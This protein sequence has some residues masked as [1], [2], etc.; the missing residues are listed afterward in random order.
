[1]AEEKSE[2]GGAASILTVIPSIYYDLIARVA[3]GIALLLFIDDV[4]EF[5]RDVKAAQFTL[6][7]VVAYIAGMLLTLGTILVFW[8]SKSL[9]RREAILKW[10]TKDYQYYKD[11]FGTDKDSIERNDYV[12]LRRPEAGTVLAKMQAE[13]VLCA[14]LAFGW[15]VVPILPGA[16]KVQNWLA[17]HHLT[18]VVV[19]VA[20]VV[21]ANVRYAF[22]RGRQFVIYNEIKDL[23]SHPTDGAVNLAGR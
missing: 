23:T 11:A 16:S 5:T 15:L 21:V 1:M 22:W 9:S 13:S 10:W 14:N 8:P 3:P 4:R 7:L 12:G 2:S 20:L 19:L 6:F 18:F 17:S